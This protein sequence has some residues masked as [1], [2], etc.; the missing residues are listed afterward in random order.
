MVTTR[1]EPRTKGRTMTIL[2]RQ[3]AAR[4]AR[5]EA[6][7]MTA[8]EATSL[9][10][11]EADLVAVARYSLAEDDARDLRIVADL[12]ADGNL[13]MAKSHAD[14]LDTACRELILMSVWVFLGG[15]LIHG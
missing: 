13:A 4:Q 9:L 12:V 6:R 11:K 8:N 1:L 5:E 15:E 14:T 2:T 7:T 10:R 3:T